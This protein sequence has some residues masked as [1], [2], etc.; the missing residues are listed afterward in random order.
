MVEQD[1][2]IT[3]EA[4]DRAD[5]RMRSIALMLGDLPGVAEEWPSLDEGERIS[6]SLDWD[7]LMGGHLPLIEAQFRGG[8]LTPQQQERYSTLLA[9]LKA[10]LPLLDRLDLYRPTVPLEA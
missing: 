8:L 9:Q 5:H 1:R 4:Q 10:A 7:Q 3:T 2:T 6:W